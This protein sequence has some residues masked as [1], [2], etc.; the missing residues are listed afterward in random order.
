MFFQSEQK[1]PHN[2]ALPELPAEAKLARTS[3]SRLIERACAQGD[4]DHATELAK[5]SIEKA[6]HLSPLHPISLNAIANFV[7]VSVSSGMPEMIP[8]EYVARLEKALSLTGVSPTSAVF[9]LATLVE[10]YDSLRGDSG[11]E[12]GFT[13][14]NHL[15]IALADPRASADIRQLGTKVVLESSLNLMRF[16]Q[17]Q[18][19]VLE[20]FDSSANQLAQ[21]SRSEALYYRGFGSWLIKDFARADLFLQQAESVVDVDITTGKSD[22]VM[23]SAILEMRMRV[24]FN[25]GRFDEAEQRAFDLINRTRRLGQSSEIVN[26]CS[27]F[28]AEM[29]FS[30][31]RQELAETL[32]SANNLPKKIGAV[33][34]NAL[35]FLRSLRA[36]SNAKNQ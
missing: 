23:K 6:G 32:L 11:V 10:Y 29:Y 33:S 16:D 2:A 24:S 20:I 15:H 8:E 26:R 28:L 4:F 13:L 22:E 19:R 30:T 18:D 17:Y 31:G 14:L 9:R 5:L 25:S 35:A 3:I 34:N 27:Y 7:R 36:S 21:Q 1:P 12:R